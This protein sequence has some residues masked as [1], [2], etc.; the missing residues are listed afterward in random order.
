MQEWAKAALSTSSLQISVHKRLYPSSFKLW[1][2]QRDSNWMIFRVKDG[3]RLRNVYLTTSNG[4]YPMLFQS[5]ALKS[6]LGQQLQ[7]S[8]WH[9]NAHA[10][11]YNK[12][13]C[14]LGEMVF[15]LLFSIEWI[16]NI[17][18]TFLPLC[19]LSWMEFFHWSQCITRLH[20]PQRISLNAGLKKVF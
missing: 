18:S 10:L 13:T 11:Y 17:L 2:L 5:P 20:S 16:L 7:Y 9:K 4:F 15:A 19:L 8:N 12:N 6:F 14:I 3:K 1:N